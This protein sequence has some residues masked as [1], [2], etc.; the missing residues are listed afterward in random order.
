M[1]E[2]LE[3]EILC[4][5]PCCKS[6]YA[7]GSIIENFSQLSKTTIPRSWQKLVQARLGLIDSIETDSPLTSAILLYTGV[8]YKPMRGIITKIVD[9][10]NQEKIQIY[11]ISGGYGIIDALEP[12]NDYEA[13]MKGNVAKYWSDNRLINVIQEIITI[14][15]PKCVVGFFAGSPSY[16]YT[17]SNYRYFFTEALKRSIKSGTKIENSG[18]FYRKQGYGV[19]AILGSLGRTFIDFLFDIKYTKFINKT[20]ITNRQD[21]NVIVASDRIK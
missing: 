1:V 10:I 18:C 11:I 21:G 8:F 5:I 15:K 19:G 17:S 3:K 20:E 6:K 16:S 12:I 9:K 13:V 7:S 4:F 2:E 14:H